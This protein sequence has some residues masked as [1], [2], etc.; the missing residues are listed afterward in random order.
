LRLLRLG[1][2]GGNTNLKGP[3]TRRPPF[4]GDVCRRVSRAPRV[5]G[6]LARREPESLLRAREWRSRLQRRRGAGEVVRRDMRSGSPLVR[7]N[8]AA[9]NVEADDGP[10][11]DHCPWAEDR[12]GEL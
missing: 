5:N 12:L 7:A 8:D 3:K 4:R 2:I 1:G 6:W 11:G 10:A 9:Q